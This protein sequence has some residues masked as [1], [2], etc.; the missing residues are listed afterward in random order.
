MAFDFSYGQRARELGF[1][2]DRLLTFW[3]RVRLDG[4]PGCWLWTGSRNGAGYAS[5]AIRGIG[6]VGHRLAYQLVVGP[7][8][9]GFQVD[10]LC[11]IR[12]CVNPSHMELVTSAE[13]TLRGLGPGGLN[14]R[15]THCRHGH[16]FTPENT[17]IDANGNRQCRACHNLRT[18]RRRQRQAVA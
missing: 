8:P 14:S 2:P 16:E 1:T 10:H 11:R 13:N 7:I 18:R 12:H 17:A 4:E 6:H 5:F 9:A 3:S 15:K